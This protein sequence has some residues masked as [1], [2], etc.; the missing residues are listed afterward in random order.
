MNKT[1]ELSALDRYKIIHP[2]LDGQTTLSNLAKEQ[3]IQLRTLRRWVQ[4]YRKNG[5]KGLE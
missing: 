1:K 2:F 5:I 3:T 4:Q